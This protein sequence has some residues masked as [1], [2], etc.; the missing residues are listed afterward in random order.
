VGHLAVSAGAG[1]AKALC[2][3]FVEVRLAG[4]GQPKCPVIREVAPLQPSSAFVFSM[5]NPSRNFL[6]A[7]LDLST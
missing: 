4:K 7:R 3:E 5:S 6:A 2:Q 1:P